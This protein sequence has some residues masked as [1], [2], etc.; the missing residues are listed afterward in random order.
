MLSIFSHAYW[1]CVSLLLEKCLH[2]FNWI[3][4]SFDVELYAVFCV[5]VDINSWSDISFE[6]MFSHS[7]GGLYDLLIVPFTVQKIFALMYSHV[8]IFTF[9]SFA[10]KDISKKVLLNPG[11]RSYC[12]CFLLWILWFQVLHL[13]CQSIMTLLL[14]MVWD[15]NPVYFASN[16]SVSKQYLL[17]RLSFHHCIFI[18]SLL[19]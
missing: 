10:Q 14:C 13:R 18:L 17:K 15:S 6:N 4:C 16:C 5:C 3:V 7:V 11:S 8:F 2:R 1:Q 12:L 9:I 19:D